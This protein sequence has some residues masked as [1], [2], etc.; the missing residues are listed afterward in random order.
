ME[1]IFLILIAV[2]AVL[3]VWLIWARQRLTHHLRS[4][5]RR[6]TLLF[7]DLRKRRDMVP[8]LLESFRSKHEVTP[9]W[10]D[11]MERRKAFHAS[12]HIPMKHEME[13]E[14]TLLAFVQAYDI[15]DVNYLD[16]EKNIK[17]MTGIIE[18]SKHDWQTEHE[19]FNRLR[20]SFPYS[21]ASAIF[22]IRK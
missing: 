3:F 13:F 20:K 15:A 9:Q 1:N 7:R 21:I 14:D 18:N 11:L 5:Q 17:N 10:M 2:A 6:E 12:G 19:S 22:G 16:A 4:F 8:Y